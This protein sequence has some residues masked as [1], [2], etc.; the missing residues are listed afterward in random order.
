MN[1]CTDTLCATADVADPARESDLKINFGNQLGG[2]VQPYN[3]T[4]KPLM[5][6]G[7]AMHLVV[8]RDRTSSAANLPPLLRKL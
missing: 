6:R 4:Q 8:E 2:E 3:I 7:F 5:V 1:G